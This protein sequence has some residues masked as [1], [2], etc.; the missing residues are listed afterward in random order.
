MFCFFFFFFWFFL[1]FLF[2]SQDSTCRF[3]LYREVV[4]N[5]QRTLFKQSCALF[6]FF[7]NRGNPSS[8]RQLS[9]Y[10]HIAIFFI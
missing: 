4:T 1:F 8:G 7:F 6:F 10:A 9:G 5:Q 3:H 2:S